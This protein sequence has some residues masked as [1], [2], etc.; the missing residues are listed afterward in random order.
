MKQMERKSAG[1]SAPETADAMAGNK[2]AAT[3][4]EKARAALDASKKVRR[5]KHYVCGICGRI[6]GGCDRRPVYED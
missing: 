3:A 5:I 6:N 1:G 2:L 4:A